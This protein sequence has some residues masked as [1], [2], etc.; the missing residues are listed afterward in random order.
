MNSDSP[1]LSPG[2]VHV[3]MHG[4]LMTTLGGGHY[5]PHFTNGE[6][7]DCTGKK[8][9]Q[10]H[11]IRKWQKWDSNPGLP[12]YVIFILFHMVFMCVFSSFYRKHIIFMQFEKEA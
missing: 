5:F 1:F 7:E 11:I 12:E 10:D 9:A 4:I 2:T 6:T 8:R 3:P